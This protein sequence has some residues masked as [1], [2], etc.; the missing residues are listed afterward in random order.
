MES[1]AGDASCTA[2]EWRSD[3][4]ELSEFDDCISEVYCGDDKLAGQL[5]QLDKLHAQLIAS[6]ATGSRVRALIEACESK[7]KLQLLAEGASWN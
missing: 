3:T 6:C 2:S 7:S 1:I 4:S 5:E